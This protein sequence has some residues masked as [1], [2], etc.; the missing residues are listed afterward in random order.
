ME[1]RDE[2]GHMPWEVQIVNDPKDRPLGSKQ[3]V[4]AWFREALGV[5]LAQPLMPPEEVLATLPPI[6]REN[7]TRPKLN[8]VL[9]AGDLFIEF[10]CNDLP[11]IRW[12]GAEVRGNIDPMPAL[13]R[14]CLPRG[15]AVETPDQSRVDLTG[16]SAEWNHFCEWRDRAINSIRNEDSN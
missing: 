2:E 12:I 9:E 11:E 6:L 3:E 1:Y 10:F 5:D 14:L 8:A 7:Y 16:S 15:W 4:I 13:A